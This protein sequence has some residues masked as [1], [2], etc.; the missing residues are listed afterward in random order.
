MSEDAHGTAF[1]A[2]HQPAAPTFNWH[3]EVAPQPAAPDAVVYRTGDEW[4]GF[5]PCLYGGDVEILEE[6]GYTVEIR[7]AAP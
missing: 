2:D 7:K 1:E 3:S 6:D 4:P 5:M